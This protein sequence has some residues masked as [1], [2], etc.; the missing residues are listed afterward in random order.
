[1][2]TK[3]LIA[4][5]A[6]FVTFELIEHIALPIVAWRTGR[7]TRRFNGPE[8]MLGKV[9]EVREWDGREGRV[10]VNGERWSATCAVAL[11]RGDRVVVRGVRG[12]VLTVVPIEADQEPPATG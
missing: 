7:K 2:V 5:A 12:L 10:F 3:L 6:A 11:S 4:V 1:M 8:G 9:A